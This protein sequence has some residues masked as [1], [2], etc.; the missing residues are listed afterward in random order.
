MTKIYYYIF[1]GY[2]TQAKVESQTVIEWIFNISNYYQLLQYSPTVQSR[3][4]KYSNQYGPCIPRVLQKR[5]IFLLNLGTTH[6]TRWSC[7]PLIVLGLNSIS[8]VFTILIDALI[9]AYLGKP[10]L[11]YFYFSK[12]VTTLFKRFLCSLIS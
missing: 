11:R 1:R 12:Q 2:F 3:L 10:S 8:P 4:S 9:F 7:S 5:H 6:K